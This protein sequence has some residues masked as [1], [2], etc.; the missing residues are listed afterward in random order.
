MT[1]MP[2]CPRGF[3][4]HNNSI[5]CT[6]YCVMDK[7]PQEPVCEISL[8]PIY[9][10]FTHR[11]TKNTQVS[12]NLQTWELH[13]GDTVRERW[14]TSVRYIIYNWARMF[15]L[16]GN[17]FLVSLCEIHHGK[18][19]S[20]WCL[21]KSLALWVFPHSDQHRPVSICQCL[22]AAWR[23]RLLHTRRRWRTHCWWCATAVHRRLFIGLRLIINLAIG[24][25]RINPSGR[26]F[27]CMNGIINTVVGHHCHRTVDCVWNVPWR[28]FCRS[29]AIIAYVTRSKLR[30]GE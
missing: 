3:S 14:S 21:D 23:L 1:T 13:V 9:V 10:L 18:S 2:C 28:S 25:R 27:C 24:W 11:L 6:N 22:L 17:R 20:L 4:E 19:G 7:Y 16:T 30:I 5:Y 12:I 26:G 8:R 29:D 15:I